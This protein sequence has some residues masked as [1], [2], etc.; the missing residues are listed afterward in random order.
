M[1]RRGWTSYSSL[2]FTQSMISV[3]LRPFGVM[4]R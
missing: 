4:S 3:S 2:R 1:T